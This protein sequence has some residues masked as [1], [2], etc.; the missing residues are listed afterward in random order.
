MIFL[1]GEGKHNLL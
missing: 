1:L